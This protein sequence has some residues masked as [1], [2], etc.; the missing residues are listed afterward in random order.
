MPDPSEP[1]SPE[2]LDAI[3]GGRL[4]PAPP[5][6]RP[7]TAPVATQPRPTVDFPQFDFSEPADPALSRRLVTPIGDL[8]SQRREAG[9]I[10]GLRIPQFDPFV[11]GLAG[12]LRGAIE[13]I[14]SLVLPGDRDLRLPGTQE[15]LDDIVEQ[16][17]FDP[18]RLRA[19]PDTLSGRFQTPSGLTFTQRTGEEILEIA[20]RE[21][22]RV[23]TP[24]GP[25]EIAGAVTGGL[26]TLGAGEEPRRAEDVS[27]LES[28]LFATPPGTAVAPLLGAVP[29]FTRAAIR[30]RGAAPAQRVTVRPSTTA[31]RVL[32]PTPGGM[33]VLRPVA[34]GTAIPETSA[35][36]EAVEKATPG[37]QEALGRAEQFRQIDAPGRFGQ[38]LDRVPGV[39][40]A[41]NFL[42]PANKLPDNIQTAFVAESSERAAFSTRAFPTR[43]RLL[44][45]IDEL[46]GPGASDGAK[47]EVRFIGAAEDS[48]L[49]DG[50]VLDIAQRPQL[51]QLTA[52]QR[53]LLTPWQERNSAMFRELV[54][55]YGA[56]I[57]EFPAPP[58]GVFLSN[59]DVADDVLKAL[60]TTALGAA[61]IGRGRTRI[62]DTAA[63]RLKRDPSFKPETSIRILQTGMD[64]WKAGV[65]GSQVFKAGIEGKTLIQ[66]IDATH[67]G[68]RAAR[69]KLAAQVRSMKGK[70]ERF[71]DAQGRQQVTATGGRLVEQRVRQASQ[72]AA[73]A[74]KR[75]EPL[76]GRIDD[77]GE[78]FGP[79]LSFLSGQVR[80]IL[81]NASRL[82][83]RGVAFATTAAAK[84]ARAKSLITELNELAPQLDAIRRRYKA[85]NLRGNQL[86]QDGIFRYFPAEEAA[87]I[88]ELRST[89][90]NTIAAAL[91]E[92]R[93]T[94]FAGDFSPIAGIQIPL[95]A[96]FDPKTAVL[97]L[98][99][100]T[101]SS[102][103][104]RDALHIFRT[105]TLADDVA[106]D[107]AGY[108]QW[109]FFT[110]IPVQAGVPREFAGGLLRF[111]PGFTKANEAMYSVVTRQSKAL[112]D[113]QR[114]ILTGQGL[115]DDVAGMIAADVS[116]KVYPMWNPARLGLSP[117]RAA[118]LRS[119]PT[120][121]S[122]V[123]RPAALITEASTGL[124]KIGL[125]QTLTPQELLATR[126]MLT[127]AASAMTLSITSAVLSA[128]TRGKDPFD[129]IK[130]VTD[131]TSGK[132]ASIVLGTRRVPLGGPFRGII[133]AI[134]PRKVDYAPFPVP[135]ANIGNFAIN[136]LNPALGTGMRLLTNKDFHG[137]TIRKG[138]VPEQILRTIEFVIEGI[139]PLTAGSVLSGVRRGL[140]TGEIAEEAAGQFAGTNVARESPLRDIRDR[141]A[142]RL[143]D[144]ATFD[145][146]DVAQR[147]AV[148]AH[149]EVEVQ[150]ETARERGV[151]Q[152]NVV[153]IFLAARDDTIENF[154]QSVA[155]VAE[156]LGPGIAFRNRLQDL[157]QERGNRL[158]QIE[159]DN[160]EAL[161]RLEELDPREPNLDRALIAYF[162]ALEEAK[163]QDPVTGDFDF[164]K[165]RTVL[166][167]L[168]EQWGDA[169]IDEVETFVRRNDHPLVAQLK[170]SREI[171]KPYWGM[172]E[173]MAE[174]LDA[175]SMFQEWSDLPAEARQQF[176]D[177]P[178]N[179]RLKEAFRQADQLKVRLRQ[180]NPE[181]DRHLLAWGYATR[182]QHP[183]LKAELEILRRI[184]GGVV[185]DRSSLLPQPVQ[186]ELEGAVR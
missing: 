179:R 67:P 31:G 11:R 42:R 17:G 68:L 116:T 141:V 16:M 90:T 142:G 159:K 180:T 130:E 125:K 18:D 97:R 33:P 109:A 4:P 10:F 149:P 43:Q 7:P 14:G 62:F 113:K 63:A 91:D 134:V 144:G 78:E 24:E 108:Q 55:R 150:A 112:F 27:T 152:E 75:A 35:A 166:A 184:Q 54:E 87:V 156:Q 174:L 120:S 32:D 135:F 126:L 138:K 59:V 129:A 69:D 34:G 71:V 167:A 139:A 73:R 76:L 26:A 12:S 85:A 93:G 140:G 183:E 22:R 103:Q 57:A 182:A 96:L 160:P 107:V 137:F 162:D 80:E 119:L 36:A 122:F 161:R 147:A 175:A 2:V 170:D 145:E 41:V 70:L 111:L 132:F 38:F 72:Q 81:L 148:N 40:R 110:G 39:N 23:D 181:I 79:E 100:A 164:A 52:E 102:I 1:L 131:P 88:R 53:A 169:L 168:R 37:I 163:L 29:G 49:I 9:S 86:V 92:A 5:P 158:D 48:T 128:L 6:A 106:R 118:A 105:Q 99:G 64:E 21:L 84:Q 114:Q 123:T 115:T 56:E 151:R 153:S 60:N 3:Q 146:L 20:E 127:A 124:L 95:G 157:Q 45:Q 98:A 136:R 133:K 143:F 28:V 77:L 65:V 165:Q 83:Q 51:Y 101:K 13:N 176:L 15:R 171:L 104:A 8:T 154:D 185:E 117:A 121:I 50:T 46:F 172:R 58:G 173:V 89:S 82:E 44:N 25:A 178:Q 186:R 66:V 74:Q 177:L 19:N 30:G 47:T 94:A 155:A 61:R